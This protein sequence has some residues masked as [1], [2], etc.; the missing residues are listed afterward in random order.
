MDVKKT[1]LLLLIVSLVMQ[2][3]C[4]NKPSEK[5]M[6]AT[7]ANMRFA[8]TSLV[9]AF[10]AE[11]GIS[12]ETIVSSSGKL[13]AQIA[14]GAPFDLFVSADMKYPEELYRLGLTSAPPKIYAYGKL[15]L[16]CAHDDVEPSLAILKDESI[17]RIAIA[18]PKTAPYGRAAMEVINHDFYS[19]QIKDKLVYGESIS[20][21]SQFIIS[22]AA[23]IGFTAKSV[24]LSPEIIGKGQWYEIDNSLYSPI[25]QGVVVLNQNPEMIDVAQQFKRFLFSA[26]GQKTLIQYG[27]EVSQ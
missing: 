12:C 7:A 27:Y 11:T 2:C 21:T 24:V 10:S 16:W 6:I 13:T 19:E 4:V 26:K 9:E 8:M 14:Q 3:G 25:E 5:L 18:N 23:S 15:V 22:G 1:S 20:Q 17:Q